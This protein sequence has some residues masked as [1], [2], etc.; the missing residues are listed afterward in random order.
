MKNRT[1]LLLVGVCALTM[2][3]GCGSSKTAET[4]A[5]MEAAETEAE[6]TEAAQAVDPED[7]PSA[8]R[9]VFAMD[10]YMTLTAYG[11]YADEAVDAAAEEIERLDALWSVG[12]EESEISQLN[13]EGSLVLSDETA[14]LVE[15]SLELYEETGGLFDITI[16]PLMEAWGFT[17]GDF[18][19]PEKSTI[20]KLLK[21]V[22]AGTLSYD[23]AKQ[24]L[25]L[26][27]DVQID[28]G[29]IAKGYT[30]ARVM[31]IFGEYGITSGIVSLGGN[32]QAWH[33]K[34]DGSLWRIGIQNPDYSG[35]L[36]GDADYVGVLT[37]EDQAVI[38][39]GGYER[40]FEEDGVTYHHILDP[41]NGYSADSGLISVT[42]VSDDGMLADGLSTSLFIMGKDAALEFWRQHS[43][44]FDTILI[45][46]DGSIT[47]TA[48]IQDSYTS[49]LEFTVA[50]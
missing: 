12:N 6:T 14:E 48:G 34:V 41:R 50:E 45:E 24:E 37:V 43:D 29:G 13:A 4:T 21:K 19:V 10:T 11:E 3:G 5:A 22:D 26:P 32:V 7:L 20:Q 42:I 44:E 25:T 36:F 23:A 40:Y 16:Y 2:L 35:K 39:S 17:T 30:S 28:L 38:T 27:E 18:G 15:E 47:I 8:T 46:E 33:R 49:D 9:D 1:K 31:E